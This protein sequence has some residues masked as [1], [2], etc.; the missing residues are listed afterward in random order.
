MLECVKFG[1][2]KTNRRIKT[3]RMD[4]VYLEFELRK[5]TRTSSRAF[6]IKSGDL[7]GEALERL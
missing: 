4:Y 6:V 7:S 3:M 1:G 2:I 5:G